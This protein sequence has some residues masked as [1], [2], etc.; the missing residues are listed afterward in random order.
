MAKSVA[1]SAVEMLV[2]K[3]DTYILA[4]SVAGIGS[5]RKLSVTSGMQNS[6]F[7]S[8][9]SYSI[10]SLQSRLQFATPTTGALFLV[11]GKNFATFGS[12]SRSKIAASYNPA[13]L[14]K[15]DSV[16]LKE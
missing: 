11:S 3:S 16:F 5:S 9:I 7:S 15:S 6:I 14:W 8:S 10:I 13:F 4:K 1:A 12:S 2:W